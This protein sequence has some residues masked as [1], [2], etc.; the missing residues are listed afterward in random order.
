MGPPQAGA[1]E[2]WYDDSPDGASLVAVI[3]DHDTG[4]IVRAIC[5]RRAR[6][7]IDGRE[8]PPIAVSRRSWRRDCVSRE[9]GQPKVILWPECTRMR[10]R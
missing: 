1:L 8:R 6:V 10:R 7:A 3:T 5:V 4:R 2:R 9:H